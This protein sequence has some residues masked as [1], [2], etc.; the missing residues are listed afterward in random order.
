MLRNID[1]WEMLHF[2]LAD[3]LSLHEE[4]CI[5]RITWNSILDIIM[6][7][8]HNNYVYCFGLCLVGPSLALQSGYQW[9]SGLHG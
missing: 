2:V 4:C 9:V 3:T 1:V 5:E 7:I 6:Y 8:K